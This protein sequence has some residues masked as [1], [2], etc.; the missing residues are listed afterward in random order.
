MNSSGIITKHRV[1][2]VKLTFRPCVVRKVLVLSLL[3]WLG[4]QNGRPYQNAILYHC[5]YK[6]GW[7]IT[8]I[9]KWNMVLN[10]YLFIVKIILPSALPFQNGMYCKIS[11]TTNLFDAMFL[12]YKM[13]RE[14]MRSCNTDE[15]SHYIVCY[16]RPRLPHF[17][18]LS[19]MGYFFAIC[20]LYVCY[21]LYN[22]CT[23][24]YV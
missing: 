5:P 3:V 22:L 11:C 4:S 14:M 10:M 15:I 12:H 17:V 20:A 23:V 16:N 21:V 9:P 1:H 19:H 6:M 2:E 13:E 18:R 8:W 24:C 7:S